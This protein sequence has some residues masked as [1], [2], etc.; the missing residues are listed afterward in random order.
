MP[1]PISR[2][3]FLQASAVS[4]VA[5]SAVSP[6]S[7]AADRPIPTDL[8]ARRSERKYQLGL[9]T[10]NI[11][12]DWDIPT[13]IERCKELGLAS[14]EL[15]STHK[16][17]VEP[18]LGKAERQEVRKRFADS[19]VRLWGLGSAC[20]Y[21]S[22]DPAVVARNIEETK[23]F[24]EL[25]AD[26]GA[27]TLKVRPNGLPKEVSEDKTLEQIGQSLRTVGQAAQAAGVE[28]CCEMHGSA[29]CE[30]PRMR[31]IMEIADH[32]AV[33]VTWNSNPADVQNET[34]RHSFEMMRQWIR[35]VH[36]NELTSKY[37]WRELFTLLRSAGYDR[38]TMIEI[39]SLQTKDPKDVMRFMAFYKA[40]WE[41]LSRPR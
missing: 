31:R 25:A 38:Y 36:I 11:A 35:N 9:V 24:I 20:E 8:V 16:H 41:E 12:G 40:L 7:R 34:I 10:Y 32:P 17:G 18:T 6:A 4:A 39:Q 3:G 1:E 29:T 21:H 15:R 27:A 28:I 14:V 23:R 30:P 5:V 19:P 2:R 37:P 26:V 33:G 22:A 13:I